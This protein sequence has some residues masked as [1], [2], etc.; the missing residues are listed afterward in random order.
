MDEIW[1]LAVTEGQPTR[2]DRLNAGSVKI[3]NVTFAGGGW[4]D[5]AGLELV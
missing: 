4:M 2:T 3:N 5:Q 1:N